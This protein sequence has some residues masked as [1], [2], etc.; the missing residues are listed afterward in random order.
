MKTDDIEKITLEEV[1]ERYK[2]CDGIVIRNCNGPSESYLDDIEEKLHSNE[3]L[4]APAMSDFKDPKIV[5]GPLPYDGY[6]II[7]P[8]NFDLDKDELDTTTL[9]LQQ[10]MVFVMLTEG[11]VMYI[12]DYVEEV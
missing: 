11:G 12:S 8:F 2:E 9:D 6:D 1:E 3:V 7:L 5:R 4:T 10:L